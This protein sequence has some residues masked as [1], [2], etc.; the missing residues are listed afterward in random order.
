MNFA[1]IFQLEPDTQVVVILKIQ[2][3][4]EDKYVVSQLLDLEGLFIEAN[5]GY[6]TEKK[7]ENAFKKYDENQAK[8]FLQGM[9]DF[10]MEAKE[11][12]YNQID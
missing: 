3:H 5:L 12:S 2:E 6:D 8:E 11:D 7:G 1:K 10:L 9:K 4:E